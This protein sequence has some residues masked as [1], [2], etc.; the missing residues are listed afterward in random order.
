[1]GGSEREL[2]TVSGLQERL[3]HPLAKTQITPIETNESAWD[4]GAEI[5]VG[6]V[7]VRECEWGSKSECVYIRGTS[8]LVYMRD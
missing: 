3:K 6:C 1:M 8:A 4:P 7:C 2:H 5:R